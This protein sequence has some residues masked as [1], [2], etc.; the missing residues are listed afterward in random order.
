MPPKKKKPEKSKTKKAGGKAQP[1]PPVKTAMERL[2][3]DE[4]LGVC[5]RCCLSVL[6]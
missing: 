4:Y 5:M 2:F 6:L 1:A 3:G